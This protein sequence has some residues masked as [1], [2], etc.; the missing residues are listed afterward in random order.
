VA[1]DFSVANSLQQNPARSGQ[2]ILLLNKK[3]GPFVKITFFLVLSKLD[4]F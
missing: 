2:N 4:N 1:A 3:I